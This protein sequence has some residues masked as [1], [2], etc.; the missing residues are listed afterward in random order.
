MRQG[1]V[2]SLLQLVMDIHSERSHCVLGKEHNIGE[3]CVAEGGDQ[4]IRYHL[5]SAKVSASVHHP[6]EEE[7]LVQW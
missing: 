7:S 2:I 1:Q 4:L 3:I 5:D 6:V